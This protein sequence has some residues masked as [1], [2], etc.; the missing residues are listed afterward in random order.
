MGLTISRE[1]LGLIGICVADT[2][3]TLL[4]LGLGLAKEANPL[5]AFLLDF[6]VS[7]FCFVKLGTVL[8]LVLLA[9]W[10]KRQNPAFVR[11]ALRLGIIVYIGTYF[12]TLLA[13]NAV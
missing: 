2:L 7:A 11:Q 8:A 10:Y 9:E 3:L 1:S 4:L 6:G 5:M 12:G 13:V